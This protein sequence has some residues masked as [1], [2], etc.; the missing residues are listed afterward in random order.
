MELTELNCKPIKKGMSA[1]NDSEISYYKEKLHPDWRIIG[2]KK[3]SRDFNFDNYKK[4]I[5]FV[6]K[7]AE[8]AETERHHPDI[9]N[10]Y[11]K[12]TIEIWTH[13]IKGLSENDFI[14][15]SKIDSL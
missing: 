11:S 14:L 10:F 2:T 9:Y 8:I 4:N 6:N 7:V 15:A 13:I 12:I 5:A 3:I 1:L